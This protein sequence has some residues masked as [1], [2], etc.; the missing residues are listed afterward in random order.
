[1]RAGETVQLTVREGALFELLLRRRGKVVSRAEIQARIWEDSFDLSTNIIDVYINAL[2]K[3]VDA[4]GRDRLI[5][6]VRGVGYRVRESQAPV[7][8]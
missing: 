2:R 3:K 1:V 7:G 6:T 4:G 5:Q 8:G